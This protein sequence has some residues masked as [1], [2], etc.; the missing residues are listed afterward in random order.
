MK[1]SADNDTRGPGGTPYI[2]AGYQGIVYAAETGADIISLSWGG[3]G[4]SQA[5]QDIINYATAQ[6]A[7]VVAAAG[8]TGSAAELQYPASYDNVVSV[9]ATKVT[10]RSEGGLFLLQR[11]GR[12]LRPG[13]P[14]HRLDRHLEH[15][16]YLN[17]YGYSS[18]T[19]MSAPVAAGVAALIR[20]HFPSYT[21]QQVGEQLRVTCD[22]IYAANPSPSYRYKLGKGRVNAYRAVTESWPSVR[23]LSYYAKDSAGGNGNG[24]FEVNEDIDVFMDFTN[25]LDPTSSATTIT[26]ASTDP[27]VTVSN[28]LFPAGAIPTGGSTN[29]HGNPFRIHVQPGIAPL[30][31]VT[32]TLVITDGAYFDRQQ[33]TMLFNPTFATHTVNS[34]WATL[35][36]NGRLGFQTT[37]SR[38]TRVRFHLRRGKST[39]RRGVDRRD[40]GSETGQRGQEP[41]ERH[42]GQRFHVDRHVRA[43]QPRIDR[44]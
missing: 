1:T 6:G 38:S 34:V 28:G 18:G 5:E 27:S 14:G 8:N 30:K 3:P 21:P 17:S 41:T 40:F 35:A 39:L 16:L 23:M 2:I 29:N 22:D 12:C 9:A 24:A 37:A 36:N 43:D 33:F 7:L 32:F 20:A 25:Y 10:A 44:R 19:S 11:T 15:V 26:L 13:R 42:T 31:V 4:Y